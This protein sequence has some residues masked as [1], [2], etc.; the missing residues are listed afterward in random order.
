MTLVGFQNPSLFYT[1]PCQFNTQT[2]LQVHR[3]QLCSTFFLA[4]L[5]HRHHY[6]YTEPSFVLHSS[7]PVQHTDIITGTQNP[8]LFYTLPLKRERPE[9]DDFSINKYLAVREKYLVEISI[10]QEVLAD[11]LTKI[12]LKMYLQILEFQFQFFSFPTKTYNFLSDKDFVP[13]PLADASANDA[14]FFLLAP[15]GKPYKKS[16]TKLVGGGRPY[17]H[18]H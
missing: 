2:S 16:A 11:T 10:F 5:T 13:P 4:S 8:A 1:L 15:L 18:C 9:T 3:T 12:I 6:R 17:G 14:S 7:L